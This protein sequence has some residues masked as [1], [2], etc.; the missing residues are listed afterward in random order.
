MSYVTDSK[1]IETFLCYEQLGLQGDQ[2]KEWRRHL[3]LNQKELAR[4]LDVSRNTVVN[5]E[6]EKVE[7]PKWLH[8]WFLG[9][10]YGKEITRKPGRKSLPLEIQQKILDAYKAGEK[11]DAI[12]STFG[13]ERKYPAKLAKKF[14]VP[15]RPPYRVK[16]VTKGVHYV[17]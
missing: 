16:N 12:C 1:E 17:S 13:V 4:F 2:I 15:T 6:T 10:K 11:V 5:W 7:P 9:L 3:R 14:G 8:T